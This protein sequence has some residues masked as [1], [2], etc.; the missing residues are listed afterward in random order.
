MLATIWKYVL[1]SLTATVATVAISHEMPS[2]ALAPGIPGVLLRIV[3]ISLIFLVFY[4]GAVI[5]LYGGPGEL[6]GFAK[7]ALDVLPSARN[8]EEGSAPGASEPDTG[9]EVAANV[10]IP[11]SVGHRSEEIP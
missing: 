10:A 6:Y 8:R 4:L 5:I 2:L 7:L 11:E 1:A 9:R 3:T